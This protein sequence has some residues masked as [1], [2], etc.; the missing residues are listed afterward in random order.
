MAVP[1][2]R[3]NDWRLRKMGKSPEELYKER[4]KR[5]EDAVQLKTPDRVPF[6]PTL[7][8][9]NAP[10]SGISCEELMYDYDKLYSAW[11]K[12]ILDFEPDMYTAFNS[13]G[14]GPMLESLDC[15]WLKWPG[16]GLPANQ[17]FQFVEKE[18]MS[19]EEYDDFLFD[20][21]DFVLRTFMSR[22]YGAL[23][24]L[25]KL[26]PLPSLYYTR[27][28]SGTAV[29]G[30]PEVAE[31]FK[32]L[33]KTGEE[34]RR[35]ASKSAEF[36]KEM[37]LLGFPCQ[38]GGVA[39]APFDYIG[40]FFRGTRGLMLDMY[41]VPDKV[42]EACEKLIPYI[43][44]GA[45]GAAKAS[46]IPGVF[47][48][49]HKGLDGFM[50]LDQFKTFYWPT[51]KKVILALIKEGLRSSVLWEGNC[52]SRL[53]TIGDIPKGKAVYAFERTDIFRAKEILG[54]TVCLKGNVP[55]SLL[56]LGSPS[57]VKEYCRRLIEKVGKGG[58]FMLDGASGIP[59]EA[60]PENIKAMAE[61]VKEFSPEG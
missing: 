41:R 6:L 16:H 49:L 42:L 20:P 11:K 60:K 4:K 35:M 14:I 26:P 24:P 53:E 8:F 46:G 22:A 31:A 36:I 44:R 56:A 32:T 29:F 25:E 30:V 47:I 34:A 27:F 28:L 13:T 58:G 37:T 38:F 59:L 61:S 9:F 2:I 3:K 48:P 51:L 5:V 40:D 17:S 15:Q 12:A 52:D 21:T 23:R 39:Y 54:S 57:E 1:R 10:Y 33:L 43:L 50:S 7:T 55:P 45:I 19:V 18:Y